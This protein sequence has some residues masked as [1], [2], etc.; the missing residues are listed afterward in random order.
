M[1][2]EFSDYYEVFMKET[3]FILRKTW[4]V[5][6][7]AMKKCRS[8]LRKQKKLDQIYNISLTSSKS[9]FIKQNVEYD[10]EPL[11]INYNENE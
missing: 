6:L 7:K 1:Q 2:K 3:H 8:I 4:I 5:K 9:E 10:V 11:Y